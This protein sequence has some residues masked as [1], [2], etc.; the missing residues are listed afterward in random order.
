M[1]AVDMPF[2]GAELAAAVL[3]ALGPGADAAV[4]RADGRAHP[5][6]AAYRAGVAAAAR[7]LL[8]AGH[9][10]MTDL[11]DAI[12]VTW[13]DAAGLPGGAA[14]LANDNTPRI[15]TQRAGRPVRPCGSTPPP[16][17]RRR[18]PAAPWPARPSR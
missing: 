1:L 10:R 4:P 3:A 5:L 11:L 12:R 17:R 15:W 9:G 14:G 8:D 6:A 13:I 18:R 2:A 7:D 16:R